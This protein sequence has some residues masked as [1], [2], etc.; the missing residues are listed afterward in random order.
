KMKMI[1]ETLIFFWLL[2][3]FY[4]ILILNVW[5]FS[6]CYWLSGIQIGVVIAWTIIELK[7]G[8]K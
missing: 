5:N 1:S 2:I 3:I 8:I 4:L 6:F 7:E